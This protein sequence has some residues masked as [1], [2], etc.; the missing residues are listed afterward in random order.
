MQFRTQEKVEA[1]RKCYRIA[2]QKLQKIHL[3]E[4]KPM[5]KRKVELET[6][7]KRIESN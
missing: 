2:L 3:Q 7:L 4:L 6:M 1:Q 5:T